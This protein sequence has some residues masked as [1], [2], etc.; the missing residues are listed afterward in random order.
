MANSV[1]P[2]GTEFTFSSPIYLEPGEYAIA[3]MTNSKNYTLRAYD[4]GVDLTN[5]GRGGNNPAVGTLYQPQSV[6]A[7]AQNLSTDIAFS[8]NRC[9]FVSSGTANYGTQPVS[10][11]QV[12][13]VNVPQI[14]PLNCT[15]TIILD[16]NSAKLNLQNNQN[17]YLSSVYT[18]DTD[19]QFYLTRP[20]KSYLSPAIDTGVFFGVGA[21]MIATSTESTSSAYVSKAVTLPEDLVSNGIFATAEVCCPYG[22]QYGS[23]VRAYVRYANRGESDLFSQPWVAMTALDGIGSPKIPFAVSSN[24]SKSEYDFRPT[25]WALFDT[26]TGIRAYQIKLVFTTDIA[27]QTKTYSVLPAIRNLRM[28]S[29]RTV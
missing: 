12:I 24:L 14:T 15:S 6:G 20:S 9:E 27:G 3:V 2:V 4:S 17:K 26:T 10:N 28:A 23:Q 19:I 11:C 29:L 18:S 1:D 21:A 8:V 13:K 22:S 16:F 25:R 7:A 5:T